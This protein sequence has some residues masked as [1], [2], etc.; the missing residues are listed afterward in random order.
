VSAG[1]SEQAPASC[2]CVE[3]AFPSGESQQQ[4]PHNHKGHRAAWKRRLVQIAHKLGDRRPPREILS[5]AETKQ[6]EIKA[7]FDGAH[8]DPER[9]ETVSLGTYPHADINRGDVMIARDRFY[10]HPSLAVT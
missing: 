1:R 5:E 8:H 3:V 10:Q 6:K 2:L 9:G 4:M 7:C